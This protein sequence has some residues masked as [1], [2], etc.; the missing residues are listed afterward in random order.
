MRSPLD[1][2]GM[3]P[4]DEGAAGRLWTKLAQVQSA[5]ERLVVLGIVT[6]ETQQG[7]ADLCRL[8]DA[9]SEDWA[10]AAGGCEPDLLLVESTAL[11][12]D[13]HGL[14]NGPNDP[15]HLLELVAW[16]KERGVPTVLWNDRD[17]FDCPR[18]I[19]VARPFD[20]VFTAD[21]NLIPTYVR[22]LGHCRLGVLPP[23]G[24][25][26]VHNPI[27]RPG[28]EK[29]VV[30]IASDPSRRN[31]E[32]A[33]DR[34]IVNELMSG[35]VVVST[36][37]RGL[38]NTFGDLVA[39]SDSLEAIKALRA[40][41]ERDPLLRAR[42]RAAALRKVMAEHTFGHRLRQI[43]AAMS[44]LELTQERRAVSVLLP[45]QTPEDLARAHAMV[46]S[47]EG[48][49]PEV[50]VITSCPRTRALAGKLGI[51]APEMGEATR[52]SDVA[53][54]DQPVAVMRGDHWYGPWYL[55]SLDDGLR[56]SRGLVIAKPLGGDGEQREFRLSDSR[57]P[58]HR[59]LVKW[60]ALPS[61]VS[62]RLLDRPVE[63]SETVWIDGLDYAPAGAPD[64]ARVSSESGFD[65]GMGF[66]E[67]AR[68]SEKNASTAALAE[69][70]RTFDPGVAP[71]DRFV[72]PPG[73]E[74]RREEGHMLTVRS[75]LDEGQGETLW[76]RV[77]DYDE[78]WPEGVDPFLY[79]EGF[80]SGRAAVAVGWLTNR[81][82]LLRTD[83][84]RCDISHRL[85]P[86][87][88]AR[89]VQ[90]G[91]HVAGGGVV[92]FGRL[93]VGPQAALER[94]SGIPR[95]VQDEYLVVAD[96]YPSY[97]ALYRYGFVHSRVRA[98][99]RYGIRANA[100]VLNRGFP[101]AFYEY[102]GWQVETGSVT[103]L[104][105]RLARS[106]PTAILVH[107]MNYAIWNAVSKYP[108]IP[109]VIW[110][111]GWDVQAWWHRAF[112][113]APGR[114]LASA[115][116]LNEDRDKLW[117]SI[118]ES[119]RSNIKLVFYGHHFREITRMDWEGV[120][121][122]MGR[123]AT[124]L[125][126]N[127]VDTHIFPYRERHPD[128]RKHILLIR[129]FVSATYAND[130]AVK[131]I[132]EL[133][134]EE[135]FGDLRFTVMGRGPMFAELTAPLHE[136][137]NVTVA[138]RFL[139]QTEMAAVMDQHGILLAPARMDGQSVSRC[140]A[141]ATGM[142]PVTSAVGG[143]PD[144]LSSTEGYQATPEDHAGVAD[145]IRDLYLHP[146]LFVQKSRAAAIRAREERGDET[147]IP[148]EI[149]AFTSGIAEMEPAREDVN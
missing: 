76:G 24:D 49:D 119:G 17:P 6:E 19:T 136:H 35:T 13:D 84:R 37:G 148:A 145:A 131:A 138:D 149:E 114:S 26:K 68:L 31:S 127:P 44:G 120:G 64:E 88:K 147:V 29:A 11:G 1:L 7:L 96:A 123:V 104:K 59:A 99:A 107:C 36:Y 32:S 117:R 94:L 82:R 111:H 47:Q 4:S 75:S 3:I 89:R 53:T 34:R 57:P 135:W 103:R 124:T 130:L 78:V 71:S 56:Y 85:Q 121:I 95:R 115:R 112:N 86:P 14:L 87:P 2:T 98:Y 41:R 67:L 83:Y 23:A 20:W 50:T 74:I 10:V 54:E 52:W 79:L 5:E 48:V 97:E 143:T 93:Y 12:R 139:T 133:S 100:F 40:E 27:K 39:V 65:T 142:V 63:T 146:D 33:F 61:T 46:A 91:L 137:P 38:K 69:D 9:A 81:S 128:E 55:R 126:P 102:E 106:R 42:L 144:F 15:S 43:V 125:I 16:C 21:L 77:T 73:V 108:D 140:E 90:F 118:V 72:A 58:W 101:D 28:H 92:P 70:V 18:S 25:P 66:E 8:V 45:S 30:S 60:S 141:M 113:L 80:G 62:L 122:D 109:L 105:D 110:L 134:E 51:R 129:P 132:L 116:R 22:E